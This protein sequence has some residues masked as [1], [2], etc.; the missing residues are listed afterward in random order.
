MLG[1]LVA[2]PDASLGSAL[3]QPAWYDSGA[4][5]LDTAEE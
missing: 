5:E 1:A 3:F 4:A 2:W